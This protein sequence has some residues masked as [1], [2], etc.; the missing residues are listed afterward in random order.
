MRLALMVI[1]LAS[2]V[3]LV[4]AFDLASRAVLR[5]FVEI[6]D[7]MAG[8]AALQ[9][10]AGEDGL[11]SEEVAATVA[12]VP[13]VELAVP[14]VSGAAFTVDESGELLTVHG[15]EITEDAAVRTYSA[16]DS[17]GLELEDPLV[18]LSRPDSIALTRIFADRRG[19]EIGDQITLDTPTGRRRFTVRGLLDAEGVARVYGG[20]LLVMDLYAAEEVFTRREL[21]NRVDVVVERQEQVE[22]VQDAIAAV[23]PP[24]FRVE[25]P[26]ERK[27]DLHRVMQSLQVMTDGMG[28]VG[29]VAAFLI[30]FNG[31]ATVFEGR[32]WQLGI[33]RAVGVPVPQVWRELLKEG[34]VLGTM[35]VA[36]GIPLGVGLGWLLLPA[37]ARTAALNYK[38]VAGDTEFAVRP[39]SLVLAAALGLGAALLAAALPAWRA[40]RV[41][42]AETVRRRG[43]EQSRL[44][45][46]AMWLVRLGAACGITAA[47]AIQLATPSAVWGLIASGLVAVGVALAAR[48]LLDGFR[49]VLIPA[50][51]WLAGPTARFAVAS[52][53]GNSRRAAMTIATLA[54]GI[55]S[56]LWMSTLAASFEQ[57]VIHVLTGVLRSDLFVSSSRVAYG[58]LEA[59]LDDKLGAELAGVPGVSAVIGERQIDWDLAGNP[60]TINA[61][62]SLHFSAPE[63]GQHLLLGERL[64]D[65]WEAVERGDAVIVSS[66]FV[67][68]VGLGVGDK[69]ALMTPRGPLELQIGGVSADFVSRRGM[70]E[71]SRDVYRD[72]WRDSQVNRFYVEVDPTADV[73][74]VRSAIARKFGGTYGLRILS[75]GEIVEYFAL[76]VRRA[77]A[78]VGVL[79][80]MIL[81][82]VLIAV[83]DTLVAGEAE[84]TRELG[85]LRAVGVERRYLRRMVLAESLALGLLGLILAAAAGL[86]LGILWVEATFPY[87]LGW[88][89]ELYVPYGQ[90]A[91]IALTT[92]LV[93]LAAALLPALHAARLDPAVALRYE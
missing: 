58:F 12:A 7:T 8:R 38:L 40:A 77:F 65:V 69:I 36:V 51:R 86:G 72:S 54:V 14:V 20:N 43:V 67:L 10:T 26:A 81:L 50:F 87:L 4:C 37:I 49:V 24:G 73:G 46:R 11:F 32:T 44:S 70:V 22:R 52:L 78:P 39:S 92:L 18:F 85:A 19:L 76:Q 66:N 89:L 45:R 62:D 31:L 91:I 13:G 75:S 48:P 23:L 90:V 35:G 53:L 16:H 15:V 41:P 63:F 83:A 34:L 42:P 30:A 93:C 79:A 17:D 55:G 74:A 21:I 64:P 82:V 29:L 5:G 33:L 59:P 1:A 71:M 61:V 28:L 68:N 3:A 60:V 47:V 84:R 27:A 88:V 80:G 56:V 57:S 2:G 9:V 6:I 25:T